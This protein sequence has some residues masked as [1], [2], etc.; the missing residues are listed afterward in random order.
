MFLSS[1]NVLIAMFFIVATDLMN[2]SILN[3]SKV[4]KIS[5]L[6]KKEITI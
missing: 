1:S 2:E 5:S 4:N 6:L 3:W